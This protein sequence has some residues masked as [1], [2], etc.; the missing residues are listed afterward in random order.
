[1]VYI[2][3]WRKYSKWLIIAFKSDYQNRLILI[4]VEIAHGGYHAKQ[5]PLFA[6]VMPAIDTTPRLSA[7]WY[8]SLVAFHIIILASLISH[9]SSKL[10]GSW[11]A[12]SRGISACLSVTS[13]YREVIANLVTRQYVAAAVSPICSIGQRLGE[14]QP[15]ICFAAKR[16]SEHLCHR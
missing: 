3:H 12:Q 11:S 15:W 16:P 10:S 2:G 7:R 1:M 5:T 9:A 6:G 14:W 13:A 8:R 4:E